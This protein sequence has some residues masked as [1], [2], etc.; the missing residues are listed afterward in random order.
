[1]FDSDSI[2]EKIDS[3]GA[4]IGILYRFIAIRFSLEPILYR[5]N[6]NR[7][8][9]AIKQFRVLKLMTFFFRN[10][11]TVFFLNYTV[12]PYFIKFFQKPYNNVIRFSY[13]LILVINKIITIS[14]NHFYTVFPYF[15]TFFQKIYTVFPYFI[16]FF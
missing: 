16:R 3:F 11:L 8:R 2:F 10:I 14:E 12:F 1:M 6:Q 5:Q 9:Q 13:L 7:N 4:R 15:I